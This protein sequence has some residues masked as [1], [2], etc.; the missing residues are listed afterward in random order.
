MFKAFSFN[1]ITNKVRFTF[2]SLFFGFCM[3]YAFFYSFFL[4]CCLP[5]VFNRCFQV[6]HFNSLVISLPFL[7]SYFLSSCPLRIVIYILI[8]TNLVC[9]HTNLKI[10]LSYN[11][12]R[13]LFFCVIIVT[14]IRSL[15]AMCSSK[16]ICSYCFM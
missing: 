10:L 4:H 13:S 16:Q 5:F 12:I 2:A 9:I 6:Y 15:Y 1:A 14:Q 3:S 8:C 7:K 11:S